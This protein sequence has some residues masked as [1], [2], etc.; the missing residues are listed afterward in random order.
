MKPNE[1]KP[2]QRVVARVTLSEIFGAKPHWTR[3][4]PGTT[5]VQTKNDNVKIKQSGSEKG[6]VSFS[7]DKLSLK[8]GQVDPVNNKDAPVHP[9]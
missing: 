8:L 5:E 1:T 4:G 9:V 7:M 3:T 6:I 2:R